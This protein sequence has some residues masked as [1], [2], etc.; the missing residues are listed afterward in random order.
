MDFSGPD[1]V[2]NAIEAGLD[3]DGSPIPVEM[4]NLYRAVMDK[5]GA[6]KRKKNQ[7]ENELYALEKHFDQNTLNQQLID[8]DWEGLNPKEVEFFFG[9]FMQGPS[10]LV[11]YWSS[12]GL[13]SSYN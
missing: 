10:Y 2:D 3:I 8:A 4:I 7:W 11:K 13:K 12:E 5:E 1:A 9:W 6:R